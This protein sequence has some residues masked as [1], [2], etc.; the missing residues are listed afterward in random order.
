MVS[1]ARTE[2]YLASIEDNARKIKFCQVY[3]GQIGEDILA[4]LPD[5]TSWRK[6]KGS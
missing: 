6:Q 5:D 1:Q 3:M 2:V 4:Q